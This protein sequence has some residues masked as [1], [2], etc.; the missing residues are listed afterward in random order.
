MR[1][2]EV[3]K[4]LSFE[5]LV[6][7]SEQAIGVRGQQHK[8][9]FAKVCCCGITR[10]LAICR[11]SLTPAK[12]TVWNHLLCVLLACLQQYSE[13]G[14]NWGEKHIVHPLWFVVALA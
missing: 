12:E 1:A 13:I 8:R 11:A 7:I 4:Q 3:D 2:L 6:M 14:H 9:L 10:T 5:E